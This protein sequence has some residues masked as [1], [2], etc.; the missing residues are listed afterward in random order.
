MNEI[1]TSDQNCD[2]SLS[3]AF[4]AVRKIWRKNLPEVLASNIVWYPKIDSFFLWRLSLFFPYFLHFTT[5]TDFAQPIMIYMSFIDD[6]FFIFC[7]WNM[8]NIHN[9]YRYVLWLG[10]GIF[11]KVLLILW[12]VL[13]YRSIVFI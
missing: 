4:L 8:W 6:I 11:S 1:I 10:R 9:N 13:L 3:I 5:Y 7:F 2:Q 12:L